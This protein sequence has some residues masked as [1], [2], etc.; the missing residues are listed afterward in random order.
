MHAVFEKSDRT[1]PY[2]L[3]LLVA[4]KVKILFPAFIKTIP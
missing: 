1:T 2:F 3:T 4:K